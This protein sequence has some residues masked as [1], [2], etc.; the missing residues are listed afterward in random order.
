MLGQICAAQLRGCLKA[1]AADSSSTAES[2][3]IA[4]VDRPGRGRVLAAL[5][6]ALAMLVCA[7]PAGAWPKATANPTPPLSHDGRWIT[8]AAG[9]VVDPAR[10]EHGLQG[11]LL[12]ARGRRL[13]R[14]RHALSAPQRVQHACAS[15]SSR[16]ESSRSCPADGRRAATASATCAASRGPSGARRGTASSPCSTPTRTCTTSA[17][18]A[19]ASPTGPWSATRRRCRPSP[20]RASPPTTW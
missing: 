4:P 8:D 20:R 7:A 6:A 5:I 15:G 13:R 14:R 1:P 3:T 9:R 12:P 18:R 16:T 19:R 10:L 11:R 17:S 2:P